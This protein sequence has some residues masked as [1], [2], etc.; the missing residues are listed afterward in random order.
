M[1]SYLSPETKY[2]LTSMLVVDPMK[3][4]TIQEIRYVMGRRSRRKGK[5]SL[6]ACVCIY[7]QNPWFNKNLPEY[8]MPLPDTEDELCRPVDDAIAHE[9][10]KVSKDKH[11]WGSVG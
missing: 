8:L 3:R 6:C 4:I 1:P 2:L 7:R 9:L 5:Y 11:S 10:S